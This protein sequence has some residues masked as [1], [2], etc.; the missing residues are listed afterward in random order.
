M[1]LYV[2]NPQEWQ[3]TILAIDQGYMTAKEK[4]IALVL[5]GIVDW[6]GEEA[7]DDT[8]FWGDNIRYCPM[9]VSRQTGT[10]RQTVYRIFQKWKEQGLISV[11]SEHYQDV[12]GF[13]S[14]SYIALSQKFYNAQFVQDGQEKKQPG[15]KKGH[16]YKMCYCGKRITK[17]TT[18]EICEDGHAKTTQHIHTAVKEKEVQK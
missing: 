17:T 8:D 16:K 6:F 12:Q 11:K 14:R 7:K 15:V 5:P 18:I 4:I 2:T 13:H 10:S 1:T 3:R 9:T